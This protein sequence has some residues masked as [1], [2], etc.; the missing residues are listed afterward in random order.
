MPAHVF[1][2]LHREREFIERDST[3]TE[4]SIVFFISCHFFPFFSLYFLSISQLLGP[5][6]VLES[7][8][9]I[10]NTE[11]SLHNFKW[12]FFLFPFCVGRLIPF[13]QV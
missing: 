7:K 4:P 12:L 5:F 2:M 11:R 3:H 8:E 1:E 9:G 13:F 10:I 6:R